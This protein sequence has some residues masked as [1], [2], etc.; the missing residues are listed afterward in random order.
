GE[1][2]VIDVSSELGKIINGGGASELMAIYSLVNTLALNLELKEVSIL[3]DGEKG[4][5]LGGHFMLD[6]PLQPRPDLSSTGVR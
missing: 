2:A 3:V 4:S 1:T 6:E 5:T